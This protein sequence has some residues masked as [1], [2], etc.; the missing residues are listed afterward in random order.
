MLCLNHTVKR[1]DKNWTVYRHRDLLTPIS[2]HKKSKSNA[3]YLFYMDFKCTLIIQFITLSSNRK[4]LISFKRNF[5]NVII[6]VAYATPGSPLIRVFSYFPH[7]RNR[8]FF[9]FH[10]DTMFVI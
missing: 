3:C 9:Q 8:Q 7:Y 2:Q 5:H 4:F 1:T 10:K 6:I